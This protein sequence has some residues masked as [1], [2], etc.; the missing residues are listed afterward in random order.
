MHGPRP[1]PLAQAGD[2]WRSLLIFSTG[3]FSTAYYTLFSYGFEFG[4]YDRLALL[5]MFLIIFSVLQLN[6]LKLKL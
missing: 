1:P 4:N 5:F 3:T 2:I 6:F